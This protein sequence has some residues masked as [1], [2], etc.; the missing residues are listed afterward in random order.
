R[1]DWS[2]LRPNHERILNNWAVLASP[3]LNR[4]NKPEIAIAPL[5]LPQPSRPIILSHSSDQVTIRR[6]VTGVD[7]P[8]TLNH[9]AILKQTTTATRTATKNRTD[10]GWPRHAGQLA[11]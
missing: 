3:F 11:N 4:S 10:L 6:D 7:P 9:F 2:T 1:N 5:S 8:S